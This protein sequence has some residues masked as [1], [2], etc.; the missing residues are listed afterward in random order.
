MLWDTHDKT[1]GRLLDHIPIDQLRIQVAQARQSGMLIVL[2][3]SLAIEDLA[4][5]KSL[6]PDLRGHPWSRLRGST[7][8]EHLQR[9][10]RAV[11]RRCR[12]LR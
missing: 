3:G 11:R 4:T 9:A 6:A 2:A 7:Y 12:R 8:R 10:C 5:L 1:R